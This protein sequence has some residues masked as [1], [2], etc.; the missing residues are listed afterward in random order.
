MGAEETN[1]ARIWANRTP[2]LFVLDVPDAVRRDLLRFLPADGA[3]PETVEGSRG[4]DGRRRRRPGPAPRSPAVSP[5]D[6]RSRVWAF[7]GCAPAP[8]RRRTCRR[9]HRRGSPPWPHQ[10]RA[11]ERLYGSW[12]PK[13]LIADEVG[14]GKTIQAGLLLRQAWLAGRA[15]RILVLAPKAVLGQWQIELREKLNLNWPIYDGRKFIW[16]PSPALR[17]RHERDSDRRAW[18]QEPAVITSAHLMRRRD[19]A[20][21]LLAEA[22]PWDVVVL[23]E[24]HHARRRGAGSQ[25]EGG[26]NALLRLM[27]G[28]KDR[29]QGLVLL[30]RDPPCRCTRWRSGTWLDLLGL[31]PEWTEE[32]FLRFFDDM[33]QPSPSPEALERMARCSG[34]WSSATARW[35][36]RTLNISPICRAS[37]PTRFSAHCAT[38]PA[39]RAGSWRHRNAAPRSGS[40]RRIRRSGV[41]SLDTHG[42]CCAVTSRP[43]R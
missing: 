25:S 16:Y 13:L 39:F 12:P 6:L 28:L 21:V 35:R 1:F 22:E 4:G 14:L 36:S 11:F 43:E 9:G 18:H 37:R 2:R 23:D 32:A 15:R 42:S 29:T 31:P 17:G 24:A 26:P 7:I 41:W 8:L 38:T 3:L 30:T 10:V 19:R 5:S 27:R 40:C 33:E 34:P 20:E